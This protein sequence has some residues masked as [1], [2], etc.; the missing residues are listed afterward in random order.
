MRWLAV[1]LLSLAGCHN[2]EPTIK[3]TLHEEYV[4]PPTDDSRF[5][6][7]LTYPKGTLDA[8]QF[9]KQQQ[10]QQQPIRPGDPFRSQPGAGR[11]GAGPS[12]F[13]Y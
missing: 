2:S 5:T 3:K 12:G 8:D 7:P 6:Q 11:F 10:Q 13:G 1:I 4:L 9:N